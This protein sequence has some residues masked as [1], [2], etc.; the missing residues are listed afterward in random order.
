MDPAMTS[1]GRCAVGPK[2]AQSLVIQVFLLLY[3]AIPPRMLRGL[4][5]APHWGLGHTAG[6]GS[7]ESQSIFLPFSELFIK[8]PN[9]LPKT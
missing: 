6:S 8:R 9:C 2:A 5:A 4:I 3:L 7:P 1:L